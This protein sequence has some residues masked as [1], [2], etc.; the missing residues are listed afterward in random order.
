MAINFPHN[1]N[2]NDVHTEASLGKSWKW[3]G[4]TWLIYSSSTT[5]IGYADLS[6][7]TEAAQGG[8]SLTYNNT[9][10]QFTFKPAAGSGGGA[11]NFTG[12]GDTP[13]SLLAG[14]WLK[15]NVGG[16]ALEW[17]D[18]PSGNDTNDYLNTASLSGTT[19]TLTRTGTQSL[20]DVT[21]DL[22]SLNSV[23]T[24]ITVANESTDTECYP[25]FTTEATGNLAPKTVTSFK[26]NSASG[27]LEAGSFKKTGGSSAEF[28]KAD[29]SVD[30]TTYLSSNPSYALNDL[31]DVDATTGVA[32]GKI[33]KYNGT[34]WEVADDQ[35]GGGGATT[36][37][38]LTDVDTTGAVN[39]KIIKYNGTSWEIADDLT[40]GGGSATFTGLNDTPNSL[41]AGKWLKVNA[42][43][44]ALE[45]T[46][47]PS[48]ADG[49]DYVNNL[50][51]SGTTLTAEFSNNSLNQSIDLASIN[52]NTTYDLATDAVTGGGIIRLTASDSTTDDIQV[53]GGTSITVSR[54]ADHK[55]TINSDITD[56]N[57]LSDVTISGSPGD[58]SVLQYDSTDSKWKPASLGSQNLFST[59]AV[60]GQSNVV[61]DTSTDTLTFSAGSNMTITTDAAND[62][63]T[64]TSAGTGSLN[65]KYLQD[66]GP[67][68]NNYISY[69][70]GVLGSYANYQ[71][72]TNYPTGFQSHSWNNWGGWINPWNAGGQQGDGLLF[73]TLSDNSETTWELKLHSTSPNTS[74]TGTNKCRCWTST[75]GENWVYQGQNTTISTTVTISITTAYL[76]V[77]DLG[78]GSGNEVYLEVGSTSIGGVNYLRKDGLSVNKLANSGTGDLTYNNAGILT[79]TP[80]TLFSGAYADLTG[81]PSITTYEIKALDNNDDINIQI[82]ASGSGTD[83][84]VKIKAGNNITLDHINAGEFE[85]SATGGGTNT[86]YD[87][88]TDAVTGG[89]I[90]RLTAS[91]STTDD[92]QVLGGTSIT[93]SRSADHKLTI[94]SD[95]TNLNSL[96][97]VTISGSVGDDSIL[98]YDTTDSKWKPASLPTSSNT[99]Y[100]LSAV[101][102]GTS[103]NIRLTGSDSTEDNVLLTPGSG[104]SLASITADG[105]TINSTDTLDTITGRGATTNNDITVGSI[106]C[107]DL[108]VN[109]TTTTVNSN[110]VN[111]GDS[112]LT[113]NS[114]ETGTPSQNG[115][116]TIERGTSTNVEIR[117]N[118][119]TDKWQFTND[120]TN[121]SDIGSSSA[122][123]FVSLSDTP[124]SYTAGKWLKAGSSSLD[125]TDPITYDMRT[126]AVTGGGIIRL[127]NELDNTTDDIQI[128][129]GTN[130]TV[131]RSADHKLTI[132][133]DI[134][135]LNSLSDVTVTGSPG[136]DSILQYNTSS[137]QWEVVAGNTVGTTIPAGTIVMYNG[138][139][140]PSGWALCDGG[141]GRPD[142]RDKF[143]IGSGSSYNRG[144][145]GGYNDAV[146]VSHNHGSGNT[147]NQSANHTHGSGNYSGNT[148]THNGHTHDDGNYA[149]AAGGSHTHQV[150]VNGNTQNQSANHYHTIG[151]NKP[152]GSPGTWNV[153]TSGGTHGHS[154]RSSNGHP[155]SNMSGIQRTGGDD[156]NSTNNTDIFSNGGSHS[157]NINLTGVTTGGIDQN[158][159]HSLNI[160]ANT[161]PPLTSSNHTHNVSGN[162][163]SGGNHSHNVNFS[164]N[165]G[166]QSAN[167]THSIS[168]EGV[169]GSGRNIPPYYAITFIIKL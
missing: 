33:L 18:A 45:F 82:D 62:V 96:S 88:A 34:S 162:S 145:T 72:D 65:I 117:W 85:I 53:L 112:N 120:G 128:L 140:A 157:H 23:P 159:T 20:S 95:I 10:G 81:K 14:K 138:D 73:F 118:E 46:D 56:L 78:M 154:Y 137:S 124:S 5:G 123:T 92:I 107:N 4:T 86:T 169:S 114:D 69:F 147:G 28:L 97:D 37:G 83:S 116:L 22:S 51:L 61:A 155:Q 165:S 168:S 89:G 119:T 74:L 9:N 104:L 27:Q 32:N 156:N 108:T 130:I 158:H 125:W 24:N 146:I 44:T 150:N 77:T 94:N 42:G 143:V 2:V 36:L 15:V 109:G 49:N 41:T 39:G 76:I 163:G 141:G 90:I 142:L 103:V 129:G 63:I 70:T 152:D 11:T 102:G 67:A 136:D 84:S 55:L 101:Q 164:G 167:H 71:F 48:S 59:F 6:V 58:D 127:E 132:S 68:N 38:A 79:Y 160:S 66:V 110:T 1:P 99:T 126:A 133:S 21:V 64:F 111:I 7:T 131:S 30:S 29:G 40:G 139:T 106:T 47:A 25:L 122:G 17:T 12:L 13:S 60:A 91:D 105:F 149:A 57:S 80:P 135:N 166:S 3:D 8:G 113:L 31:S 144:S 134:T 151:G 43:A 98:Q 115:G 50:S 148:S 19:L 16:T 161:S 93:V 153:T 100:T 87:L 54:S 75:D 35:S 52:N 121:Y 26:L